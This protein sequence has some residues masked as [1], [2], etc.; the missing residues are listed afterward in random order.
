MNIYIFIVPESAACDCTP[1]ITCAVKRGASPPPSIPAV[2]S[3]GKVGHGG[4]Q[5]NEGDGGQGM[6][7]TAVKLL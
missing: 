6:L 3:N 1:R 5:L 4:P 2:L 7:V